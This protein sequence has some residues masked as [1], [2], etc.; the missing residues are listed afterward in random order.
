MPVISI[1]G[2]TLHYERAGAG[3]TL[4][5]FHSL[6]TNSYLWV[7]QITHWRDRFTCIAFDARGH[8]RSTNN[9]GVT[10]QNAA[11]DVHAALLDLDLL[12]A[13]IIGISMG[14]LQCALF[15]A[16]D[17]GA[18][19][20]IVY[21]DSF[22]CMGEAGAAR[23]GAIEEKIASMTMA[24]FGADYTA[25]T[26]LPATAK[27]QHQ[28]LTD[29]IAGMTAEDYMQTVRS[30]FT[31]DVREPLKGIDKP[32]RIIVGEHDP[33]TP[34]AASESVRDL[35]AGSDLQV[36]PDAAHLSNIDNPEGF[37]AVV[38]PF[39]SHFTD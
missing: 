1:N 39:L 30:I 13:N 32:T 8:G 25:N 2:E 36:I 34:L 11:E 7:Q 31:E 9:G 17:P 20:S 33:R 10:M 38:E 4:A 27:A 22:A 37:R 29:A 19:T 21:A 16:L 3:P 28:A 15:H 12:P 26:L 14:A 5:L 18:V 24:E 35:V 23:I 6:G